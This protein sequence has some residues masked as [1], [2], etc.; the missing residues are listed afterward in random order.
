MRLFTRFS[1]ILSTSLIYISI[2]TACGPEPKTPT[3]KNNSVSAKDTIAKIGDWGPQET[4]EGKGVNIQPDG[5]SAVWISA[6]GIS[7]DPGTQVTFGTF[8]G[9]GV[10]VSE[11]LVTV[12]VPKDVI[13]NPGTYDVQIIEPNG[14]KSHV[15]VFIT[16]AKTK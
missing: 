10:V 12:G 11:K 1:T 7:P 8:S 3:S 2:L 16:K 14:R 6:S 5:V 4:D 15:G 13:T 9:L